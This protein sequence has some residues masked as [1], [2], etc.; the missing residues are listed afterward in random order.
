M[1]ADY[2]KVLFAGQSHPTSGLS[3][4]VSGVA[5]PILSKITAR[6]AQ[7]PRREV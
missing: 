5:D 1:G 4:G 3:G 6:M 7:E 2:K